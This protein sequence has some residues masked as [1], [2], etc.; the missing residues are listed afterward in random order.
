MHF[1]N[2]S[3]KIL[4]VTGFLLLYFTFACCNADQ[5]NT[6]GFCKNPEADLGSTLPPLAAK[7]L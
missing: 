2:I 7:N 5:S 3:H 6:F 4:N 1:L